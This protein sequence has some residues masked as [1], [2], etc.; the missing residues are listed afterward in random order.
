MKNVLLSK[1]LSVDVNR[2]LHQAERHR[3]RQYTNRLQIGYTCM[4]TSEAS[5]QVLGCRTVSVKHPRGL[6]HAGVCD[7]E[8]SSPEGPQGL[9]NGLWSETVAWHTVPGGAAFA[10]VRLVAAASTL[11][12][13]VQIGGGK[14]D[15][16]L[17]HSKVNILRFDMS[18]HAKS[19]CRTTDCD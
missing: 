17:K 6:G 3:D 4:G 5:L 8:I 11:T 13:V 7:P 12:K 10:S 18:Y 16:D 1:A 14:G 19:L 9:K 2:P 15:F